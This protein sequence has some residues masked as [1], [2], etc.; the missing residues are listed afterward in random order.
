[1][2][3]KIVEIFKLPRIRIKFVDN[4]NTGELEKVYYYFV[5]R[6]PKYK[7]FKN[8]T[9]GVMLYKLPKNIEDY[10]KKIRG[11]NSVSYFSR[12]CKKRGYYTKYFKQGDYLNEIYSINT[13]ATER[14]GRKMSQ[15]YLK[16]P[17]KEEEKDCISYFGVFTNEDLLVG[18]IKLVKTEHLHNI[19]KI[20]GHKNYL[21]DNIMY[22][23]IHDLT[24]DLIEK[25]KENE[26]EQYLMYD[27]YFGGSDGIRMFKKRNCF[28]P[29]RVRW[30]YENK[31]DNK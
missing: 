21:N 9:V 29:Y 15:S 16:K 6:H 31:K 26:L 8:K 30:I 7:V 24:I 19:S 25:G 2:I 1:M 18:Y 17:I 5:K 4:D 10:E 28:I 23:L 27:T 11:K 20:L 13:S 22:L 12:R 3:K 14:Q